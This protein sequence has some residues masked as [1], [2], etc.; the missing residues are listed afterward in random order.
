MD[1]NSL[2]NIQ[3]SECKIRVANEGQS[4]GTASVMLRGKRIVHLVLYC[5]R[6]LFYYY[7][8]VA[9]SISVTMK[10]GELGFGIAGDIPLVNTI[11]SNINTIQ[12]SL[13]V[14]KT[15]YEL[16]KV[17]GEEYSL[18]NLILKMNGDKEYTLTFIA[19]VTIPVH[20]QHF[21]MFATRSKNSVCFVS[22]IHSDDFHCPRIHSILPCILYAERQKL[23]V[24]VLH[25]QR[26]FVQH[27]VKSL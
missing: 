22:H 27:K 18:A 3:T 23:C 25:E 17:D 9:E 19:W 26:F 7:F 20:F 1:A 4:K 21:Y 11:S 13:R 16:L 10:P 6:I 12:P 15:G 24:R 8:Q 14:L 2:K 5:F